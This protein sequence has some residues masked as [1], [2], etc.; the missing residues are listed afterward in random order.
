M[1]ATRCRRPSI[2][3]KSNVESVIFARQLRM[4]QERCGYLPLEEIRELSARLGVPLHRLHEVI[5][6]FPHFRLEPPPDVEV[7]V[8]RD[9]ACHLRAR[10][11]ACRCSGSRRRVR[12]R[13]PRQGRRR[14][15]PGPLRWCALPS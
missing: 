12:R 8:C 2:A 14:L 11:S 10:R 4:I 6:F 9:Q 5:S 7:H 1:A 3:I 13:G 15:V